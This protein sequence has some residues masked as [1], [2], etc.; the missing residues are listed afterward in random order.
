MKTTH[1]KIFTLTLLL[2][3]MV[4]LPGQAATVTAT[5]DPQEIT[6]GDSTQLTVTADRAEYPRARHHRG[7]PID[8][9]RDRQRLDDGQRL[10]HLPDHA[11]A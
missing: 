1:L 2:G 11:A 10:Q 3:A 6:V 4:L 7:W 9:D 8:A 5:L